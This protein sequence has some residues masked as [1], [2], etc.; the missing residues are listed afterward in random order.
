MIKKNL[1]A[2]TIMNKFEIFRFKK[3]LK[4]KEADGLQKIYSVDIFKNSGISKLGLKLII[5]LKLFLKIIK[6][7][8]IQLKQSQ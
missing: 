2:K 7:V 4:S 1:N 6:D 8:D 3:R 5:S